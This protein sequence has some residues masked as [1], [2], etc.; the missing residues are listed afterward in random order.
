MGFPPSQYER[1]SE[2]VRELEKKNNLKSR[3]FKNEIRQF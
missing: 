3:N 2:P 1:R